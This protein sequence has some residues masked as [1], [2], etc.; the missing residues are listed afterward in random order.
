MARVGNQLG[1]AEYAKI[2]E[3]G[4]KAE[5]LAPGSGKIRA[6]KKDYVESSL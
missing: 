6:Y 4:T 1:V 2:I 3:K 5:D